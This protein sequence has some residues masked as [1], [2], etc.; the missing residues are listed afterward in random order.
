MLAARLHDDG[1]RVEEIETPSP[2][3][4]EVLVRVACGGDHSWRAGVARSIGWRRLPR[5]SSRASRPVAAGRCSR[6]RHSIATASLPSTPSYR[7]LCSHRSRRGWATS[8][9]R[10]CR[11]GL[12][13]WQALF[14]HGRLARG[15]RVVVMGASGG[16]GHVAVACAPRRRSRRDERS[17]RSGLRHSRQRGPEGRARGHD[18]RG[19]A[20]RVLLHRRARPR[21]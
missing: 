1:L 5:T 9:P 20:G 12:T 17:G 15:E 6:S 19:A 2:G 14:V 10:L 16:V 11:W 7:L 8:R 13:A 18:R 21:V 4:D 3:R